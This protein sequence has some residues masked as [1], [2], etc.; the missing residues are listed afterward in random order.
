MVA[1]LFDRYPDLTMCMVHGGGALPYQV[2]RMQRGYEGVPHVAATNMESSPLD[3]FAK[4]YFDTVL[5][6]APSL[7]FLIDFAGV[8]HV[9]LGSDYPFPM[10]DLDP[11]ATLDTIPDLTAAERAAILEDNARRL[12]SQV[13]GRG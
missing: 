3:V 13:K 6:T 11:I 8:D 12:I 2:G 1:G 4:L 9:V 10:G 7:R 5:F